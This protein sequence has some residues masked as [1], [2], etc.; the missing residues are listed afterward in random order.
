MR[1]LYLPVRLTAVAILALFACDSAPFAASRAGA[2]TRQC[3]RAMDWRNSSAGGPRDLYA[4]V[5]MKDVWHFAMAQDCPGARFP[6]PVSIGDVV[7]G[8]SNEICS[9]L[10]LQITVK[11]LGG[12]DPVACIVK[13]IDKLSPEAVKAL[14]R[15]ATP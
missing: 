2:Q 3:F 14:P 7:S 12:S 8:P 13:S 11:P 10:D 4:R 5:G 15:K 6:G 1:A 9:G